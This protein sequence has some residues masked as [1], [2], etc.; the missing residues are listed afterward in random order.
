MAT[1]KLMLVFKKEK[2]D[3]PLGDAWVYIKQ[4]STITVLRTYPDGI[5]HQLSPGKDAKD[6]AGYDVPFV[7]DVPASQ[8]ELF[9]SRGPRPVADAVLLDKDSKECFVK[10]DI[11]LPPDAPPER[12]YVATTGIKNNRGTPPLATVALPGPIPVRFFFLVSQMTDHGHRDLDFQSMVR[13]RAKEI[14]DQAIDKHSTLG[15][16][17]ERPSVLRFLH[18]NF[19]VPEGQQKDPIGAIE[20]AQLRLGKTG[21]GETALKWVPLESF[22]AGLDAGEETDPR[23]FVHSHKNE[24]P[25]SDSIKPPDRLSIVHVHHSVRGA[26]PARDDVP[27][28]VMEIDIHAHA[29]LEGPVLV[30]TSDYKDQSACFHLGFPARYP[31]DRDCRRRTDFHPNMGEDPAES[32]NSPIKSGGLHA[33]HEFRKALHH[34]ATFRVHGCNV[35]D[36]ALDATGRVVAYIHSTAQ[37]VLYQVFQHAPNCLTKAPAEV[38]IDMGRAFKDEND[39]VLDA[40]KRRREAHHPRPSDNDPLP[41]IEKLRDWHYPIDSEFFPADGRLAFTRSWDA[42]LAFLVRRVKAT[43]WFA[44]AEALTPGTRIRVFGAPPGTST[45]NEGA[46][47]LQLGPQP[48]DILGFYRKYLHIPSDRDEPHPK[49]YAVLDADAVK[50]IQELAAKPVDKPVDP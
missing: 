7:F 21:H 16:R 42:I 30:N 46:K 37:Q 11:A 19:N 33:L 32:S 44:V 25:T 10:R 50:A 1:R 8:V 9:H 5:A 24:L 22:D 36:K 27:G 48:Y 13:F 4:G 35:Q 17:L 18:F 47:Y 29:W 20:V 6:P 15:A 14:V 2:G 23:V 12:T 31:E 45:N 43:Y 38:K 49:R 39:G 3:A 34:H 40:R 26:P 41:E 28:S